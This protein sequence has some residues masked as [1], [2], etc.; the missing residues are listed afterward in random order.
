LR[1]ELFIKHI[2]LYLAKWRERNVAHTVQGYDLNYV[3][4]IFEREIDFNPNTRKI[5][6]IAENYLDSYGKI[7]TD[8][9]EL[10]TY[11]IN[12]Y[13]TMMYRGI[14]GTFVWAYHQNL[15]NYIAKHIPTFEK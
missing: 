13:K 9:S 10:E 12:I 3:G 8:S 4:V 7:G 2:D 6:I 5:E 1:K 11:I 14:K 15:K